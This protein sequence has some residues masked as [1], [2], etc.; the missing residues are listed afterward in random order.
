MSDERIRRLQRITA[1]GGDGE[2]EAQLLAEHV[3]RG[4]VARPSVRVVTR[5]EGGGGWW[6]AVGRL[7]EIQETQEAL[8]QIT[9]DIEAHTEALVSMVNSEAWAEHL[10]GIFNLCRQPGSPLSAF[11]INY[12]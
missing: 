7:E 3:R 6:W 12:S 10:Q 9:H 1:Q 4:W 5:D 2:A 8:A 11:R